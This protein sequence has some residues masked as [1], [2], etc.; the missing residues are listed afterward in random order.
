MLKATT[1][2]CL[3]K[4]S[5][6]FI[7]LMQGD[8]CSYPKGHTRRQRNT[9]E[10][11]TVMVASIHSYSVEQYSPMAC[12]IWSYLV[13]KSH[14]DFI[15]NSGY[16]FILSAVRHFS[17]EL[18]CSHPHHPPHTFLCL[19]QYLAWPPFPFSLI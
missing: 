12:I 2:H 17:T 10:H 9:E 4:D 16:R 13:S 8:K 15:L 3:L 6:E 1:L 19:L 5:S 7:Q 18:S 11:S 14:W